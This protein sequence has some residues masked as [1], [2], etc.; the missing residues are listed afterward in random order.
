MV[1]SCAKTGDSGFSFV[2][3]HY[4]ATRASGKHASQY[5]TA[6]LRPVSCSAW[7]FWRGVQASEAAA[8]LKSLGLHGLLCASSFYYKTCR[9]NNSLCHKTLCKPREFTEA[10]QLLSQAEF[11][12]SSC[13]QRAAL[14]GIYV[15]VFSIMLE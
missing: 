3:S 9:A 2:C 10:A 15:I 6:G 7:Q 13:W 5:G 11:N 12:L 1:V 8:R 4:P 14:S